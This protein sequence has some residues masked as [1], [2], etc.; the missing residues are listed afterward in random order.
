MLIITIIDIIFNMII[1]IIIN[2]G[3]CGVKLLL[4]FNHFKLMIMTMTIPQFFVVQRSLP[5]ASLIVLIITITNN[6]TIMM[7]L[8]E[9]A[10]SVPGDCRHLH[11]HLLHWSLP[12]QVSH[13][14]DDDNN[15]N[16]NSIFSFIL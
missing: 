3:L 4:T 2:R 14:D 12:C 16:S 5:F 9:L 7:I 15:P 8:G 1:V 13:H 6:I 11:I 10:Y